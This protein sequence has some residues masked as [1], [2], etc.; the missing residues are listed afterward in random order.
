MAVSLTRGA[1]CLLLAALAALAAA[2]VARAETLTPVGFGAPGYSVK[3]VAANGTPG[4]EAPGFGLDATWTDGTAPF[5][6]LTTCAGLTPP[7]ANAGWGLGDLLLRKRFDVPAGTGA[8][9][10][11]VRVDNDVW[12]Y[13]NGVLVGSAIH[14]GCADI[15]PPAP[16]AFAAGRLHAGE[17]VLA[18]RARDRSDQRYIDVRLDVAFD[19][20]DG[21]GVGDAADNCPT[22]ANPARRTP[23]ATAAV[24][25]ATAPSWR[26]RPRACRPAVARTSRRRSRTAARRSR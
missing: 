1:L 10:V 14:E 6:R 23:T 3:A 22:R 16:F 4:F 15:N 19:D 2:G 8:G 5:G 25:C 24:T 21:D 18:V 9:S 26:S 20:G 7:T 13:L 17:N 12:V 11:R